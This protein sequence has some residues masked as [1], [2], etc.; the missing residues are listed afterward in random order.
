MSITDISVTEFYYTVGR[1]I[2]A[3]DYILPQFKKVAETAP[4]SF[5]RLVERVESLHTSITNSIEVHNYSAAI[6]V[7]ITPDITK[8]VNLC[9]GVRQLITNRTTV[10]TVQTVNETIDRLLAEAT[11]ASS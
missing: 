2:E 5:G 1:L 10:L 6:C 8:L 7:D 4:A 11:A 3:V 9:D